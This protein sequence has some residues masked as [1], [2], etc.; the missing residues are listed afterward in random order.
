[1][2]NEKFRCSEGYLGIIQRGK[3]VADMEYITT[4]EPELSSRSLAESYKAALA[5]Q[6][7]PLPLWLPRMIC[8]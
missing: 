1:M 4:T 2:R 5:Q 8:R 7:P 3:D 6:S